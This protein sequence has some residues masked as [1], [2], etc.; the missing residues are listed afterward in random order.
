[1]I[2]RPERVV[3]E[4]RLAEHVEHLLL[5]IVLVHRD[6]LEDHRPLGVDVVERGPEHHVGHH[7]ERPLQVRVDDARVDRGR[8]LARAGV[9]LGPHAVEDLVDLERA[10]TS[11]SP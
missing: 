5:R 10:R 2:A 8:L 11:T 1:M 3:S 9:E 6:L 7:V 4:H